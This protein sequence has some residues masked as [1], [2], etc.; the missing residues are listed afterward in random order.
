MRQATGNSGDVSLA[1][2]YRTLTGFP[3]VRWLI[4]V[5]LIHD[6]LFFKFICYWTADRAVLFFCGED[7][8]RNSAGV[9]AAGV[10]R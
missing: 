10:W 8:A 9:Y 1:A 7:V 4:F 2:T 5:Y 3:V 6:P